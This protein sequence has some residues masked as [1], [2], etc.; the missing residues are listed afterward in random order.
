M[1]ELYTFCCMIIYDAASV[2]TNCPLQTHHH[3]HRLQ[4]VPPLI[5]FLRFVPFCS[6]WRVWSDSRT[7][8][9]TEEQPVFSDGSFSWF[10]LELLISLLLCRFSAAVL[11]ELNWHDLIWL[12][13]LSYCC[14][15]FLA[16]QTILTSLL[17]PLSS[18][19]CFSS[20]NW[21]LLGCFCFSGVCRVWRS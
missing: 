8:G 17:W 20:L 18:T 2:G 6:L 21:R 13:H 7:Q 1:N 3:H 16:A 11:Y 9:V 12:D 4:F 5:F 10:G 14:V 19:W 15:A